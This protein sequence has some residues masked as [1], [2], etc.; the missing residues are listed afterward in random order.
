MTRKDYL[1]LKHKHGSR[2][3]E[4]CYEVYLEEARGNK[5]DK[6]NF[7]HLFSMFVNI[8]G[9]MQ[10]IITFLDEKYK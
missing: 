4:L 9:G 2:H 7:D 10:R 1:E 5:I 3:F 8:T 6:D